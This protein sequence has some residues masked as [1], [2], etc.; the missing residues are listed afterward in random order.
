[1]M[2]GYLLNRKDA[3]RK[4]RAEKQRQLRESKYRDSL[5]LFDA[6]ARQTIERVRG[7]SMLDVE[8]LFSLILSVRHVVKQEIPGDFVE[9]GVWRGGA[10]M[11]AA[12]TLRQLG[13]TDRRIY[14][15]DTF[16]G[17]PA[18]TERDYSIHP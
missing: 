8:R 2:F 17:M 7:F 11:A 5:R 13:V 10:A 15:Y 9:C 1:I 14:L 3:K 16:E 6:E 12:L 18:P 4:R